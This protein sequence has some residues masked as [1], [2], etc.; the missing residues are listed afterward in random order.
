MKNGFSLIEVLI[1]IGI[2]VVLSSLVISPFSSFR[3]QQVL[4][5]SVEDVL[6]TIAK[7]RTATLAGL[8]DSA[9]GVHFQSDSLVIFPGS[10]YQAG[11]VGNEVVSLNPL[12][13]ISA[14]NLTGGATDITFQR[15]S[16]V[17]A[18]SGTITVSL[19]SSST[20]N[21]IIT[22]QPTGTATSN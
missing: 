21:R 5:G 19:V 6:S 2:I 8:D 20:Q 16:G 1:V 11:A 15:L 13:N 10:T 22:I 7:A 4:R 9:Y 18:V 3:D 12:T 14:I 17:T